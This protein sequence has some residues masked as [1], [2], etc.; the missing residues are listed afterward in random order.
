MTVGGQWEIRERWRW[1]SRKPEL[2]LGLLKRN[3]QSFT[4]YAVSDC[5]P[6]GHEGK[7]REYRMYEHRCGCE[8]A[9]CVR[10]MDVR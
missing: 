3:S 5:E 7:A 6:A 2:L 10:W 9:G 8:L 4:P 1:A